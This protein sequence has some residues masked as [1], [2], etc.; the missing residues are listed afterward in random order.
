[1]R[2]V[3][4]LYDSLQHSLL[5][6]ENPLSQYLRFSGVSKPQFE[7]IASDESSLKF[8]RLDYDHS[9]Q[10]LIVKIMPGFSHECI[11]ARICDDITFQ[12][13]Q[14]GLR[15]QTCRGGATAIQLLTRTKEPDNC[16][17][18]SPLDPQPTVVVELGV[19]ES[20]RQLELDARWWIEAAGA[21][22]KTVMTINVNRLRSKLHFIIWK[23]PKDS[24]PHDLPP[25]NG[26]AFRVYKEQSITIECDQQ[27]MPHLTGVRNDPVTGSIEEI[28]HLRLELGHFI[29]RGPASPVESD[30]IIGRELLEKYA[31]E[32][33]TYKDYRA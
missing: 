26:D 2:T 20:A 32:W 28:D 12:I 30:I 14:M 1:M 4:S 33:Y 10:S 3:S 17:F 18:I 11:A 13:R 5:H 31:R 9:C 22:D 23:R 8:T 15:H 24:N 29:G 21:V 7:E 16:W 27:S 25:R 19:S 6:D